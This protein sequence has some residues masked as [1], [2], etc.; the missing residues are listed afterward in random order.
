[1]GDTLRYVREPANKPTRWRFLREPVF[2]EN[3][4]KIWRLLGLLNYRGVLL[5]L[6][7]VFLFFSSIR[8]L[9]ADD[10][11]T[12]LTQYNNNNISLSIKGYRNGNWQAAK[13]CKTSWMVRVLILTHWLMF[14]CYNV[15]CRSKS[16]PD[17]PIWNRAIWSLILIS[18]PHNQ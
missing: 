1:M 14:S 2:C 16:S 7:F 18:E 12:R 3:S 13:T 4:V 6:C 10:P 5:V 11:H 8:F 17:V 9:S 15:S